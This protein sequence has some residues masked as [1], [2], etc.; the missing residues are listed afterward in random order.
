MIIRACRIVK[1]KYSNE[2]FTGKGSRLA[3]GRW[4]NPGFSLVYVAESASLAM[5]EMLVHLQF[6]D[7]LTSYTSFDLAFDQKLVTDAVVPHNWQQEPAPSETKSLGDDWAMK[8]TSAVLKVPSVVV[9]S[10]SNYLLNPSHPDY[11]H[12]QINPGQ[13]IRFDPRLF[14]KSH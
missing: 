11:R 10:E 14:K 8:A 5:L 6:E 12:I 3:G 1:T 4:N 2:A 13:P 9:P 7:I